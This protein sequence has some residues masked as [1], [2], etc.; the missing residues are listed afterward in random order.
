MD[1]DAFL[2]LYANA[3]DEVEKLGGTFEDEMKKVQH[4]FSKEYFCWMFEILL[5]F[6]LLEISWVDGRIDP[7]EI[8]ITNKITK[9][10]DLMSLANEALKTDINWEDLIETDP[11]YVRKLLASLKGALEPMQNTFTSQ[12]AVF[13]KI[14]V[15][16]SLEEVISGVVAMFVTFMNVD[17][18]VTDEEKEAAKKTLMVETLIII[19]GLMKE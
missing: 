19:D 12:F 5:Q 18:E 10:G 8:F 2:E 4:D 13:D 16:N 6:S 17:G 15:A 7:R 9:Y 14:D 1:K 3:I 11:D